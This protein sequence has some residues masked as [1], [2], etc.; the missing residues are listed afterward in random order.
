MEEEGPESSRSRR[1]QAGPHGYMV[2]GDKTGSEGSS[3]QLE[4]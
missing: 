4:G 3:R 2:P 1:L